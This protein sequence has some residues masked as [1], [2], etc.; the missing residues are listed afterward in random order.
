MRKKEE[1]IIYFVLRLL[2][3]SSCLF[4]LFFVLDK[5]FMNYFLF[6][7]MIFLWFLMLWVAQIVHRKMYKRGFFE[8]WWEMMKKTFE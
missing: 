4:F 6:N 1:D 8:K 2:F 5:T 7:L 3:L